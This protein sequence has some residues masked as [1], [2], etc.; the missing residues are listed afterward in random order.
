MAEIK[1]VTQHVAGDIEKVHEL[2]THIKKHIGK[3]VKI[4]NSGSIKELGE[5]GKHL[6]EIDGKVHELF[7]HI[8][9]KEVLYNPNKDFS[10]KK[11]Y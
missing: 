2:V 3:A 5:I 1:E 10:V 9:K 11:E 7:H 6:L 8:T 4:Y